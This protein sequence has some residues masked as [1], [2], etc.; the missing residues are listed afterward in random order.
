MTNNEPIRIIIIGP[1]KSDKDTLLQYYTNHFKRN[2]DFPPSS[3]RRQIRFN[4]HTIELDIDESLNYFLFTCSFIYLFDL[5]SQTSKDYLFY[6]KFLHLYGEIYY[7]PLFYV[8]NKTAPNQD[9]TTKKSKITNCS[10][11]NYPYYE[12]ST[13][14]GENIYEL[15]YL[16]IREVMN[17]QENIPNQKRKSKLKKSHCLCF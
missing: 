1:N 7:R 2:V 17:R 15:F 9:E 13:F 16:L 6:E 14:T 4:Q 12:I 5:K 10:T 8:L 3:Q 11:S